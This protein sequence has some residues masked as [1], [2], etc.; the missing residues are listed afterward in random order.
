M[1]CEEVT[2]KKM[3]NTLRCL[4]MKSSLFKG[5][6]DLKHVEIVNVHNQ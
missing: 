4:R 5:L 2:A 3:Y 1:N 6:N